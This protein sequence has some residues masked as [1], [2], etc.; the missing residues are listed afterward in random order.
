MSKICTIAVDAMGGDHAPGSIVKGVKLGVAGSNCKFKVILVGNR[1]KILEVD[2]E[3]SDMNEIS[4]VHASEIIEMCDSPVDAIK[5]KKDSSMT[6]TAGLLKNSKAD[7]VFSAGNTGAFMAASLFAAGKVEGVVRPTIGFFYPSL[8]GSSFLLD[9]GANTDCKPHHL[10]QFGLMGSTFVKYFQKIDKPKVAILSIGEESSKGNSATIE[11]YKLFE[12]SSLN[13][14]GNIEGRDLFTD[15]ADV[16]VCD[17]FI[18]NIIL[19]LIETYGTTLETMIKG[20]MDNNPLYNLGWSLLKKPVSKVME[21]FDYENYGGVP[22]LGLNGVSLIGH[23]HS[24]PN[25]VKTALYAAAKI[26]EQDIQG[27]IQ[28]EIALYKE[29]S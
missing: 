29:N 24:S 18:G 19:K 28:K 23:G 17:G 14:I 26:Y 12:N 3:I 21:G 1:E 15:K 20:K 10:F 5:V 7:A 4:I 16:V 27:H 8:N 6:V 13:F 11:A 9:A 2:P 25:A 22:L